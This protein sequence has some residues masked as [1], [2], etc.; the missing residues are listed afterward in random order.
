MSQS[1]AI[2]GACRRRA[3]T[4]IELLVVVA[5]IGLLAALLSR[6]V[7]HGVAK[8][9]EVACQNNM[10][11]LA[12]MLLLISDGR[13]PLPLPSSPGDSYFGVQRPLLEALSPHLG[14]ASNIL[15]C[16]R[17]VRL[18]KLNINDELKAGRI[19]YYYWGWKAPFQPLYLDD[20]TN[21]W[22]TYGWNAGVGGLVLLTDR[23][24]DKAYW[25][26]AND[27]QFHA[28]PDVEHSLSVPGTLAVLADGSV[29]KIAPRP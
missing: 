28:P 11:Q 6:T 16:P 5:I 2:G 8:G 25:P 14:G 29:Q 24:R 1:L 4:L 9:Q 27:W 13:N 10:R 18:E 20:S 19:G 3:F 22:L 23:F 21:I 17:S 26:I 12:T 15:F 7:F